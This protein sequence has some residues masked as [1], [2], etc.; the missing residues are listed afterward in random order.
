MPPSQRLGNKENSNN[1]KVL[2]IWKI[3]R[4]FC[5]MLVSAFAKTCGGSPLKS[6]PERELK[7]KVNGVLVQWE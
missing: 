3:V 1:K 2:R 7:A 6:Y 4:T 5:K